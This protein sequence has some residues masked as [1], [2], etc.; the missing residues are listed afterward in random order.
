M[1]RES[2]FPFLPAA[3]AVVTDVLIAG[4]VVA[5]PDNPTTLPGLSSISLDVRERRS[6][7]QFQSVGASRGLRNAVGRGYPSLG[8][9]QSAPLWSIQS[10]ASPSKKWKCPLVPPSGIVSASKQLVVDRLE[11][12][13]AGWEDTDLALHRPRGTQALGIFSVGRSQPTARPVF[14][15]NVDLSECRFQGMFL[16][17]HNDETH[18]SP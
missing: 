18:N 12:T 16:A 17:G 3:L 1:S 4:I 9:C 10:V 6:W 7:R 8:R 14:V 13:L 5:L 15:L 11:G 2:L